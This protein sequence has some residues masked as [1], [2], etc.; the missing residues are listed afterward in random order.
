MKNFLIVLFALIS[1]GFI[2]SNPNKIDSKCTSTMTH[3]MISGS[4]KYSIA[5]VTTITTLTQ[6]QGT[7]TTT[8][9]ASPITMTIKRPGTFITTIQTV[10]KKVTPKTALS[11]STV[12][13]TNDALT[14]SY[15]TTITSL[16]ASVIKTVLLETSDS[17]RN[18]K[19]WTG[20]QLTLLVLGSM[21]FFI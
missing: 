10:T 18:F 21:V 13:V 11:V 7:F 1:L 5:Y 16:T 9:Y 20:L 4:G 3:T 19:I 17:D 14:A 6:A 15:T 8:I 12:T 2:S